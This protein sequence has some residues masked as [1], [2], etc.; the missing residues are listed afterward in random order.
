MTLEQYYRE[1]RR[2]G[3]L[4]KW[5]I[6]AA[7]TLVEWDQH[8]GKDVKLDIEPDCDADMANLKGDCFDPRCV[9]HISPERLKQQEKEFE[10]LVNDE[11]VWGIVARVRCACC[12]RWHVAA[13]VWGFIGSEVEDSEC[14]IDI[15][16]EALDEIR[17]TA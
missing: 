17:R 11:G 3:W 15:M 13:S 14:A 12:G 9:D 5:A 4:A 6:Y 7:R 16:D 8:E 2:K 10:Q 1:Y